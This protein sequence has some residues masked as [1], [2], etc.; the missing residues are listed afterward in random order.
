MNYRLILFYPEFLN[1]LMVQ[2][3]NLTCTTLCYPQND[4]EHTVWT[5]TRT[6][7]MVTY[8]WSHTKKYPVLSTDQL[9]GF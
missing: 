2:K 5:S 3:W 6:E 8:T 1:R 9:N 7:D 4:N